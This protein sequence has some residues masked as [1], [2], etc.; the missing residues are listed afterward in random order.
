MDP[1]TAALAAGV[2]AGSTKYAVQ[3]VTDRHGLLKD[4][5]SAQFPQHAVHVGALKA[6]PG[7]GA[8]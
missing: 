4:G 6:L 7:H 3:A 5:L 2:A 1:V 8:A